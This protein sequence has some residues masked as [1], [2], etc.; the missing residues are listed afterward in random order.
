MNVIWKSLICSADSDHFILPE[1]K[2]WKIGLAEMESIDLN[3]LRTFVLLCQSNSL[4]RAGIK[5]GISESAV[6]KQMTKLREQL[7]HPLF[8]RTTEGLRPTHY[9]KSILPKIEQALSLLHTATSPVTF[10]PA[11]YEGP[12]TLAFF[13]YTLEFSGLSLFRELSK[14]FPKAQIELKTWTSDTEQKLEDG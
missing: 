11:T 9:S 2:A 3:L 4:K 10:D 13:A 8:E 12:I 7:G 5:L 1:W 14:T 6:S